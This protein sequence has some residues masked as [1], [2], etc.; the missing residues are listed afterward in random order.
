MFPEI[1]STSYVEDAMST[2]TRTSIFG[3]EPVMYMAVI[4]AAL[5]AAA[6]F[7]LGLSGEQ[8]GL[9]MA[10]SAA[11]LGFIARSRVTPVETP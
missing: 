1:G 11:V 3:R 6:G 5:A 10:V 2:P 9:I 4:Q 7:G 8:I